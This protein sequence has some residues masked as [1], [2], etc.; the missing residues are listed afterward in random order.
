M[1]EFW[2]Y[3]FQSVITLTLL[4]GVYWFLLRKETFFKMHRFFLLA[5][6]II[7]LVLPLINSSLLMGV[8]SFSPVQIVNTGYRYVETALVMNPVKITGE[9]QGGLT[10]YHLLWGVYLGGVFLLL[11]RLVYQVIMIAISIRR[12]ETR[13]LRD[14]PVNV[15]NRIPAP[16][17]FFGQIFI[18]FG[19][20]KYKHFKEILIHEAEHLKQKHSWVLLFIELLCIFQWFNPIVWIVGRAVR[21]THEYLAETND[22]DEKKKIT[23]SKEMASAVSYS[24]SSIS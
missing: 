16:F 23:E 8:K 11:A 14:I 19:V 5:A 13:I 6:G 12:S 15:N 22:H 20:L 2:Q 24:C 1:Y 7:S 4:F 17:S 9:Q 18:P 3:Q 21:E 10:V